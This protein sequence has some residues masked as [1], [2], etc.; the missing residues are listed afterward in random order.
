MLRPCPVVGMLKRYQESKVSRK[1]LGRGGGGGGGGGEMVWLRW[2]NVGGQ[3]TSIKVLPARRQIAAFVIN[4]HF[5][6]KKVG[7]AEQLRLLSFALKLH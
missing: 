6:S 7:A 1:D 4:P 5:K 2:I 3:V